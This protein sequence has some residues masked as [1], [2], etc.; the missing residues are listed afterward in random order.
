MHGPPRS[1]ASF[2]Q[3]LGRF[4]RLGR[5]AEMLFI[6]HD[7]CQLFTAVATVAVAA[8]HRSESLRPRLLSWDLLVKQILNLVR[9]RQRIGEMEI[10][11]RTR[12][13]SHLR[14]FLKTTLDL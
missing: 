7:S 14:I 8:R 6:V 4:G 9:N 11:R 1:A 3:L 12:V 5:P 13:L 10:I 2:L